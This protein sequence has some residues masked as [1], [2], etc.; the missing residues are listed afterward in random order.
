MSFNSPT[1]PWG[2]DNFKLDIS[3]PQDSFTAPGS[4]NNSQGASSSN[5]IGRSTPTNPEIAQIPSYNPQTHNMILQ[6][7]EYQEGLL[8]NIQRC[9][10]AKSVY[11]K[12]IHV[13]AVLK[14]Y[15][16]NLKSATEKANP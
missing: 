14:E 2:D 8:N 12:Q 9:E 11:L 5:E 4:A 16:S 7:Q 13:N 6:V 15:L 3:R 10:M 1:N